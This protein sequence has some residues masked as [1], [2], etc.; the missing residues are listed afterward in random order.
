MV[1]CY[2]VA[3]KTANRKN[4]RGEQA[5]YCVKNIKN[6]LYWVGGTDRRL[7]L[8]E[9]VY[10]IP[11]GVSYNAYVMMDEKLFCWTRWTNRSAG[12]S[13][14]TWSMCWEEEAWIT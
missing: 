10:P 4:T 13:L 3:E 5:M 8:F 7:A 14:K 12:S 2:N 1:L 6:E 9:N 11:R